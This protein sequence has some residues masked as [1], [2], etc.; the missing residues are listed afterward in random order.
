MMAFS[1][2]QGHAG[3][4]KSMRLCGAESRSP[5]PEAQ[6]CGDDEKETRMIW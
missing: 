3:Y 4:E 1:H 5:R 6:E 2:Q